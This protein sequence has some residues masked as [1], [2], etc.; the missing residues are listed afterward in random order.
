MQGFTKGN[1]NIV[2]INKHEIKL[3]LSSQATI[4][5]TF[6][7]LNILVAFTTLLSFSLVNMTIGEIQIE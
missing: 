5:A 7:T 4:P 3:F 2:S 6:K 1:M